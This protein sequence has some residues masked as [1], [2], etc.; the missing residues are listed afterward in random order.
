ME[1]E[2]SKEDE[3]YWRRGASRGVG[4][5]LPNKE[6]APTKARALEEEADDHHDGLELANQ[7]R[8]SSFFLF[9]LCYRF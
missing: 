4:G 7:P 2:E 9:F 6:E 1:Q 3:G 5:G 8:V